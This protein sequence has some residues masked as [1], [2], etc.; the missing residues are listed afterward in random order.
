MT[1]QETFQRKRRFWLIVSIVSFTMIASYWSGYRMAATSNNAP[2]PIF[3][4]DRKLES[5]S[6][7]ATIG[8]LL[9]SSITVVFVFTTFKLQKEEIK[10]SRL[11]SKTQKFEDRFFAL[12]DF[13]TSI[14]EAMDLRKSKTGEQVATARDCFRFFFNKGFLND[15]ATH[16]T[17]TYHDPK[18]SYYV[19]HHDALLF[20]PNVPKN[21]ILHHYN[22]FFKARMHDLGHYF[23]NLLQLLKFIDKNAPE[24]SQ[25]EYFDIV[26]AQLSLYELA[27]LYYHG[28]SPWGQIEFK[29][30]IEKYGLLHFMTSE[31]IFQSLRNSDPY[32]IKAF[33]I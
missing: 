26:R 24:D 6:Y 4:L 11:E 17:S 33:N 20:E 29:P 32:D 13:N 23:N 14:I 15:V 12:L 31:H 19:L 18:N 22:E 10:E 5:W 8:G 30:L 28:L 21:D 9:L 25:K 1:P 16:Y 3:V 27:L 7:V 2:S